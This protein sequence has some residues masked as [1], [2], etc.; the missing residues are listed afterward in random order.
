MFYMTRII[1]T[2]ASCLW[3]LLSSLPPSLPPSLLGAALPG[4]ALDHPSRLSRH[5]S[6]VVPKVFLINSLPRERVSSP[7]SN[8]LLSLSL[9]LSL[10][11][12]NPNPLQA[13]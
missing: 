13:Y 9:S 6:S 7:Q 8:K 2:I 10:S 1:T 11:V 3:A 5:R 4:D 12:P